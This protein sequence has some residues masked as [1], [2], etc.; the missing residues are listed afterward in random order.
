MTAVVVGSPDQQRGRVTPGDDGFVERGIL[1]T[2]VADERIRCALGTD[3]CCQR[4]AWVHD[5]RVVE[6]EQA[7]KRGLQ[8]GEI[9][10]AWRTRAAD[11]AVEEHVARE[12]IGA[13]DEKRE[14]AA[15]M[16]RRRDCL[17]L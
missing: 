5:D 14:V 1:G 6:V 11:G 3:R 15:G 4:V 10:M 12:D 16:T 7:A 13:L 17:H 8:V 9:R 2:K